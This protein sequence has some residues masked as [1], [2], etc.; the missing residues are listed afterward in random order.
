MALSQIDVGVRELKR[1]ETLQTLQGHMHNMRQ[2]VAKQEYQLDQMHVRHQDEYNAMLARHKEETTAAQKLLWELRDGSHE[3]QMHLAYN[4]GARDENMT[5]HGL[6]LG[7]AV[8]FSPMYALINARRAKPHASIEPPPPPRPSARPALT[9]AEATPTA[10]RLARRSPPAAATISLIDDETQIH[11]TDAEPPISSVGASLLAKSLVGSGTRPASSGV[12]IVRPSAA[13]A[14]APAPLA[15]AT[16]I[17]TTIP[18]NAASRGREIVR[19][20]S[21]SAARNAAAPLRGS[22]IVQRP[23]AIPADSVPV[24]DM[25]PLARGA[26]SRGTAAAA[27]AASAL[28]DVAA[29]PWDMRKRI[30]LARRSPPLVVGARATRPAPGHGSSWQRAGLAA[31]VASAVPVPVPDPQFVADVVHLARGVLASHERPAHTVPRPL[32]ISPL[33]AAV[34]PVVPSGAV[35]PSASA[36]PRPLGISPLIA[37]VAPVGASAALSPSASAAR[38]ERSGVSVSAQTRRLSV[39]DLSALPLLPAP[40]VS[41]TLVALGE[42]GKVRRLESP[43]DA[44]FNFNKRQRIESTIPSAPPGS[45]AANFRVISSAAPAGKHVA[46]AA[47]RT[48]LGAV[49]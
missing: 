11:A 42:R 47:C 40:P 10:S 20:S 9:D 29:I 31:G 7:P 30:L 14:P 27:A 16:A 12:E 37:A 19:P 17:A 25:T 23:R 48:L 36:A 1:N 34:A 38:P 3:L 44:R 49:S 2:E 33:I 5:T 8:P 18:T 13:P 35:S 43:G 32:G 4:S 22:Q 28:A 39:G 15:N 24:A 45:S 21:A 41:P 26:D 46:A 6:T